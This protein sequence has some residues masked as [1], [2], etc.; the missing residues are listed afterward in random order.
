MNV[1]SSNALGTTS[2]ARLRQKKQ[3][4]EQKQIHTVRALLSMQNDTRSRTKNFGTKE[5]EKQSACERSCP[6]NSHGGVNSSFSCCLG[7]T[8][9][10]LRFI[11]GRPP[12]TTLLDPEALPRLSPALELG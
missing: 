2:R 8:A 10:A 5:S 4:N 9:D 3:H 12:S 6:L 7:S 11:A 1:G